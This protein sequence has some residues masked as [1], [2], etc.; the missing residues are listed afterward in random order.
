MALA[1]LF[2]VAFPVHARG[3]CPTSHL[4]SAI[5]GHAL[6]YDLTTAE[7]NLDGSPVT[8]Q[9]IGPRPARSLSCRAGQEDL[10]SRGP[11]SS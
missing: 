9:A 8:I 11:Y 3:D 2:V 1:V 7:G 4:F 10:A 6:Q 5:A